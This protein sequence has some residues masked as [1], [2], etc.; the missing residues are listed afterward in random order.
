MR[1]F[2]AL[3]DPVY[4]APSQVSSLNRFFLSLIRDE[5][6]LPFVHLAL[7]IILIMIP[8]GLMMFVPAIDG[9][10]W[11]AFAA[12][13]FYMN[14]FVFKGPFGL[15]LHC[16]S[17]RPWFK[18]DYDFLNKIL[19]WF[20]GP[21]FGQTPETY[22]SHH[23][24]MHHPENNMPTDRSSTMFYQRDSMKSFWAYF[25]RFFFLG[26]VELV[27]YLK[28]KNRKKLIRNALTGEIGFIL[29]CVGLSFVNFPATF[30]VFILPFLIS[31]LIMMM[32]NF[33]QHT[34]VDASD[35][36][37]AYKNSI[38]C[39]NHKYN[40]KCWNDGYH[41]SHHL[42]P[43]MHWTEH[44]V[45]LQKNMQKYID[46]KAIIFE[47][48]DFLGVFVRVMKKDYEG[49]AE[50]T[51]N[52]GGMWESKEELIATMKERTKRISKEDYM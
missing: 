34:F 23:I 1:A 41:I 47:G 13:Y 2:A 33:A 48:I 15:M 7:K 28:T 37:N 42:R 20:V 40:H 18:K 44:P 43:A 36:N 4:E 50:K 14:N 3:H 38:T 49:L 8:T 24:G 30:M 29:M 26:V 46:N 5:R 12:A 27:Q 32:G 45:H 6:D 16:T 22:F 35:P 17:H 51:V 39:I 9:W 19:P 10:L 25:A 11:W 21:F 31:R 52:L